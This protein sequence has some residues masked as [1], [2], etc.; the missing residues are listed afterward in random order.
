MKI[1]IMEQIKVEDMFEDS[2]FWFLP[3]YLERG[4]DV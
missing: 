3:H 1:P 4:G 2:R